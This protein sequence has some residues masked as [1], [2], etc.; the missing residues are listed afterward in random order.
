MDKNWDH[1]ELLQEKI[2]IVEG[3][4]REINTIMNNICDFPTKVEIIIEFL[5]HKSKDDI[6]KLDI[7]RSNGKRKLDE[8]EEKSYDNGR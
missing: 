3:A 2:D 5:N 1:M 4:N 7:D 6:T 8:K